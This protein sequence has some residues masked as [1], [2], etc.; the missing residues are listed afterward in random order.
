VRPR[1]R[2]KK[3]PKIQDDFTLLETKEHSGEMG[4]KNDENKIIKR[5][6]TRETWKKK[7]SNSITK[8]E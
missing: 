8:G 5:K 6:K 1:Y 3:A 7:K 2:P 4:E